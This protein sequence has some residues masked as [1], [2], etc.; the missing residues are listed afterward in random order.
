MNVTDEPWL[1]LAGALAIGL[2]IGAERER[3]KGEGPLRSPAGIRTFA[4][5]SLLGGL[6]FHLGREVLLGAA[7]LAMG[8]FCYAAY[9]RNYK[10]D[11]GLTSETALLL[12]VL[13]GGLAQ[14]QPA[15]ASG[16]AVSV[17]ILLAVRS[18]LHHLVRAA[19]SVEELT[20]GLIF[21]AAVLVVLPLTPDRYL[22]PYGAVNPRTIWKIVILLVSISAAGYVAVRLLG[23]RF[24]LPLT[25]L[26]SGFVSSTATIASMASRL[27]LEP[28]LARPAI[29][30]AVL[31][32]VAT[33]VQMAIVIGATSQRTLHLLR[34]PLLSAGATALAYGL[35]LTLF[36]VRH[37]AISSYRPGRPFNVKTTLMLA[38]TM[39][40]IL[41]GSASVNAWLGE[42]GLI[43]ATVLAGF[44]D[45]HSA[46]ISVTSLVEANKLGVRESAVPILAALTA[47]TVTKIV[48]AIS[49]GG[50]KFGWIVVPGLLLVCVAAWLP[51]LFVP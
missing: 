10:H 11:P 44:A 43:V 15:T 45:P 13:L 50:R 6:S 47:N 39:T 35:A 4:L 31:S 9:Q 3:R 14:L 8:A 29:A 18:R 49:G 23:P 38:A 36:C 42:S 2:L 7:M 30:G 1:R 19:L 17:T 48:I 20:D 5:A 32:T 26:A 51:V 33:I 16:L 37:E 21:A 22:G 40:A 24:G 41:I 28:A 25:G 12:T 27:T 46:A 34:V